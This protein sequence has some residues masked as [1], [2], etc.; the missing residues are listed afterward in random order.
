MGLLGGEDAV[1]GGE[2]SGLG[3]TLDER[4]AAAVDCGNVGDGTQ[5]PG[6]ANS[7]AEIA[8]RAGLCDGPVS[9]S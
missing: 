5:L 7:L 4:G 1:V 8:N 2:T 9:H 6:K 3:G